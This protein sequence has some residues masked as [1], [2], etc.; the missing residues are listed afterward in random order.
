LVSDSYF[1]DNGSSDTGAGIYVKPSSG[2]EANVSINRTQM[3]NNQFG[4]VADGT[5]GGIINSVVSGNANNGSRSAVQRP[6][7]SS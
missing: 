3:E 7:W 6:T 5:G 1:H 4:I 2:V